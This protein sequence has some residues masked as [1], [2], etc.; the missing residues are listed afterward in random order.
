[1]FR[2]FCFPCEIKNRY[3]PWILCLFFSLLNGIAMDF[4]FGVIVGH[5]FAYG[6]LDKIKAS[7]ARLQ[8]WE[9]G[10]LA[11]LAAKPVTLIALFPP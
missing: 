11:S 3:Y 5:L 4:F 2:L 6:K 7:Q 9:A 1:M 10:P 8:A